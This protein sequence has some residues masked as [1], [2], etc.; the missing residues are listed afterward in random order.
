MDETTPMEKIHGLT[1]GRDF[2]KRESDIIV[3]S[4]DRIGLEGNVIEGYTGWILFEAQSK[5]VC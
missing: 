4:V 2:G 3:P 5:S 1:K